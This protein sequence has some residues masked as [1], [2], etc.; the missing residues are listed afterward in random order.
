MHRFSILES[1]RKS[2]PGVGGRP[3]PGRLGN[4]SRIRIGGSGGSP[5][6]RGRG[7]E[8]IS[9][10]PDV[11]DFGVARPRQHRRDV[12]RAA[13]SARRRAGRRDRIVPRAIH[14]CFVSSQTGPRG[15]EPPVHLR[16]WV[17]GELDPKK[18]I[19]G[20]DALTNEGFSDFGRAS[21]PSSG[22]P[23]APEN[24]G[25]AAFSSSSAKSRQWLR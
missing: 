2:A 13:A 20:S 24:Q 15:E 14:L 19:E 25:F 1:S 16:R 10:T 9:A 18:R 17:S 11:R 23:T 6:S 3:A 21:P 4:R 12:A 8:R 5:S 22:T 7:V